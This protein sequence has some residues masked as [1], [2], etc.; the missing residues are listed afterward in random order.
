MILNL[1]IFFI[2][3]LIN[4][5]SFNFNKNRDFCFVVNIFLIYIEKFFCFI[6]KYKYNFLKTKKNYKKKSILVLS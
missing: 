6:K 5:K 1:I 3:Y 4:K 2:I